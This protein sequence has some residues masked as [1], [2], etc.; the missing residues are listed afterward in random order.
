MFSVDSDM[1][2]PFTSAGR[3][4]KPVFLSSKE[5]SSIVVEKKD[6]VTASLGASSSSHLADASS[7]SMHDAAD[8]GGL[9]DATSRVGDIGLAALAD[10]KMPTVSGLVEAVRTENLIFHLSLFLSV[11]LIAW[12]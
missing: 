7:R 2:M 3:P 1:P 4:D 5:T 8:P 10:L 6:E 11:G 9:A 12:L